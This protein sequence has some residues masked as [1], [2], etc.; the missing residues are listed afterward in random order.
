MSNPNASS[1]PTPAPDWKDS[2]TQQYRTSEIREIAKVLE[3]L[4]PSSAG[5]SS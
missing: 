5:A 4:E 3:A 2:V 1:N